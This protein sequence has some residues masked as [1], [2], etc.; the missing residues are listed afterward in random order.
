M[1]ADCAST[2]A[3]WQVEVFSSQGWPSSGPAWHIGPAVFGETS[4]RLVEAK[5]D[6]L[7]KPEEHN[8]TY[9]EAIDAV[10]RRLRVEETTVFDVNVTLQLSF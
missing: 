7:Y 8:P 9:V 2:S 1:V 6:P 10:G 5:G 3:I 4:P